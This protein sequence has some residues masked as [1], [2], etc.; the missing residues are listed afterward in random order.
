MR[1]TGTLP[2][3]TQREVIKYIEGVQALHPGLT[4]DEL[5]I[6]ANEDL[7]LFEEIVATWSAG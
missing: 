2:L 4:V 7:R 5:I 6:M 1:P 3:A